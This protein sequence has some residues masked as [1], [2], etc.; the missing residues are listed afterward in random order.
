MP[1]I[2]QIFLW[3]NI[4]G[5]AFSA[6]SILVAVGTFF[7]ALWLQRKR[8]INNQLGLLKSLIC[9]LNYLGG[10]GKMQIGPLTRYSHLHWYEEAFSEGGVPTHDMKDIDV[11][12]YIAELDEKIKGKPTRYLKEVLLFIHDSVVMINRWTDE[13]LKLTQSRDNKEVKSKEA[14]KMYVFVKQPIERLKI[15]IPEAVR[16]INTKWLN[17]PENPQMNTYLDLIQKK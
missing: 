4:Y 5:G 3:L 8:H 9:E 17:Q 13:F 1:T 12:R 6:I 11:N 2:K 14:E 7:I 15:L 16:Q 10:E